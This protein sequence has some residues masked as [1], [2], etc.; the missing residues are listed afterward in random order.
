MSTLAIAMLQGFSFMAI[1]AEQQRT[2]PAQVIASAPQVRD[3]EVLLF[4]IELDAVTLS[5]S[6]TAYGNLSDPHLPVGELARLLDLNLDVYPSEL[7]ITGTLGEQRS[8]VAVDL[9][10]GLARVGDHDVALSISEAKFSPTD[11]YL[12]ASALE[13]LLP[14]RFNVDPEALT[15]KLLPTETLPVQ[16]RAQRLSRANG[17]NEGTSVL[18]QVL[19]IDSPYQLLTAPSFDVVLETGFDTRGSR[20][21]RRYD[22]RAGGDLLFSGFQA[23][24]GSNAEGQPSTARLLFERRSAAGALPFGA[25]RISAGDVFTPGLAL[26]PRAAAGRGI[27]FSTAP[28]EQVSVFNTI[29]LHGELPLGHDAELYVNDVLRSTQRTPVEGRYQFLNVPLVFGI[30]II[31]IVL[32]GPRGERSESVRY[33]NVGSGQLRDD[34]TTVDIGITQQE[35]A[36]VEPNGPIGDGLVRAEVG[37]PRVVASVAHGLSERVTIVGGLALY[38]TVRDGE[39]HLATAGLRTSVHA[40]AVQLDAAADHRGGAALAFGLAGQPLGMSMLLRH[41]EYRGGFVDEN[42]LAGSLGR[43]LSRRTSLIADANI[44]VFGAAIPVSVRVSR[45]G[46][47]DGGASWLASVRA[48]TTVADTMLSTGLDYQLETTAD[49]RQHQRLAGSFTASRL[50]DASWQVRASLDYDVLPVLSMRTFNVTAD[51]A[52]SSGLAL[53]FGLGQTLQRPRHT[54]L[55]AGPVLRLPFGDLAFT[56]DYVPQLGDWRA[57]VRFSFGTLFDGGRGRYVMTRPGPAAGGNAVLQAFLDRDANGRFSPGDEPLPGVE[58]TGGERTGMTDRNGRAIATGFGSAPTAQLQVNT[59][60]I[61]QA[62]VA[63][64]PSTVRLAPRPGHVVRIPYAII[65]IGELYARVTVQQGGRAVGISALRL[66]LV[67]QSVEP[68]TATTEYDGSAVF[69][70]VRPGTYTLELDPEQAERLRMRLK[71]AMTVTVGVDETISIEAEVVF[72]RQQGEAV[73]AEAGSAGDEVAAEL[74][75]AP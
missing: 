4:A 55:Q 11:I 49:S 3:E 23:Y 2:M 50:F 30:N 21:A 60:S 48:S 36:V 40:F 17:L 59:E 74:P 62:Y 34:Q 33:L 38:S 27:S 15:V 7:R 75:S 57:G 1:P 16:A 28:L 53:R 14:V 31:R 66:R 67:R 10:A 22:L 44:P 42:I 71:E 35:R 29:D 52:V 24:L 72:E 54:V 70:A 9:R 26:G 73:A 12:R 68:M 43:G 20:F 6:F 61:E 13:A 58:I 18:G 32:H 19:E 47:A 64:A 5:D 39:R 69:S 41:S 8:P 51:R 63:D 56:G 37:A 46:Y 25:R 45:A 65:P